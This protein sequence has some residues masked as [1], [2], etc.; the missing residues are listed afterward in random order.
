MTSVFATSFEVKY[1]YVL[2]STANTFI[3]FPSLTLTAIF[4]GPLHKID[5]GLVYSFL[6]FLVDEFQSQPH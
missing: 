1:S 6:Y 5:F 2:G 4:A 3:T